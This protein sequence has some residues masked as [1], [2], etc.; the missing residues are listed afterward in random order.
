MYPHRVHALFYLYQ[1]H[2]CVRRLENNAWKIL[3][4]DMIRSVSRSESR[5]FH[6]FRF[7]WGQ[8]LETIWGRNAT[9][10]Q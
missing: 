2:V 5:E 1:L 10:S 8:G 6:M 3:L 4:E 9:F 7:H